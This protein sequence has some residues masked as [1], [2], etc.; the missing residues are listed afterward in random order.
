MVFNFFFQL[1][2]ILSCAFALSNGSILHDNDIY[3]TI[4]INVINNQTN[5]CRSPMT[6][7][8]I[9]S[10]VKQY[11]CTITEK[12]NNNR[13]MKRKVDA[14]SADIYALQAI[15]NDHLV[16]I[17]YLIDNSIN[18]S[19]VADAINNYYSKT[20]PILISWRDQIDLLFIAI[21]IGFIIYLL[22]KCLIHYVYEQQQQELM[23]TQSI[24]RKKQHLP[25]IASII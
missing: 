20:G 25:S 3:E 5:Q 23:K 14:D 16:M 10:L 22:V 6:L 24:H 2:L 11:P 17:N 19:F 7:Q 4:T 21:C 9:M 8:Q 1:C 13:R 12:E 18:T 15:L